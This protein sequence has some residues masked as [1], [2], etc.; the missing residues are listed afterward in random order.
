MGSKL[1]IR[2]DR[3]IVDAPEGLSKIE[4]Q[5]RDA[6]ATSLAFKRKNFFFSQAYQLG[7]W[8][9]ETHL[10]HKKK[11]PH[12]GIK[13]SGDGDWY[14]LGLFER[15]YRSWKRLIPVEDQRDM[16][17]IELDENRPAFRGLW[18]FQQ[19][20]VRAVLTHHMDDIFLPRGIIHLPP[21]TGKTRIAGAILDQIKDRPAVFVVERVDLARQAVDAIQSQIGE[22]VGL[23][24]DGTVDIRPITVMTIQSLHSAFGIK[25]NAKD[26]YEYIEKKLQSKREM[27]Q[28]VVNSCVFITD[29]S[30]HATADSYRK[31]LAQARNAYCVVGLSGT[32][33]MDDGSDLLLESVLGPIIYY[34]PYSYMIEHGYLVPL[35][36]YFYRL[37]QLA[38]YSGNYQSVYKQAVV[39]NPIKEHVIVECA[40]SL[41]R[42][43][44]SVAVMT[45]Q[46]AHAKRLASLIPGAVVL[47]GQERGTYRHDVYKRLHKKS[48][49][50]IV[51]TVFSE[52]IDVPSLDAGINADG[53]K[54]SRRVFQRL[55]MQTPCVGKKI[56]YYIDFLHEEEYLKSHSNRRLKFYRS[57]SGFEVIIRDYRDFYRQKFGKQVPLL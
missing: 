56:G 16:P 50:C 45:V 23:V 36:I 41:I 17:V 52:G 38:C 57:E 28:L 20:A 32:P 46:I 13:H 55:R 27:M 40:K 33:W 48:V 19:E 35:K 15:T 42:S 11:A 51:S 34:R 12:G 4:R 24:G 49:Q 1:I 6:I 3:I 53:G 10:Y 54:D 2:R 29:E 22:R 37:P 44:K 30:H 21:R 7:R 39:D 31:A 8:S 5:N 18:P 47:T 25:Y 43:G 14:S 26:R 9:G